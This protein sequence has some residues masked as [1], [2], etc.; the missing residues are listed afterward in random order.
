RAAAVLNASTKVAM[1]VGAGA[2]GA[3]DEILAVA[4]KLGAGVITSLLGQDVVPGDVPYHTQQ[5]GL[6]GSRPSHDLLRAC[7]TFFMIG[8]NL[9]DDGFLAGAGQARGVQIRPAPED[10]SLG[11]PKGG[12]VVGHARSTLAALADRLEYKEDR[13]WQ[14]GVIDGVRDWDEVMASLADV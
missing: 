9:P 3:T 12:E 2:V 8:S 1:L 13:S 6:L 14:D 11:D 10:P 5:A 7:D 4:D